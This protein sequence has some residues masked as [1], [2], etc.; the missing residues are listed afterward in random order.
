MYS[1]KSKLVQINTIVDKK[2]L[3]PKSYPYTSSTTKIL[4]DNFKELYQECSHLIN[5]STK[6]LIV[7]IGS[8]DGNL[9][10]NFQK[11]H[12]VLGITPEKIGNL[13]NKKGI[14]T[15]IRYFDNETSNYILKKFG[16]AKIITA[17][18]VF[19]H[20]ENI[21][22]VVKNVLKIL[23]DDGVFITESHYLVTLIK[24]LQY[25]TIYHEHLRY[26]SL[27]SLKY[28]FDRHNLSIFHAK[29]ISTHGGSIR[30]YVARKGKFKTQQSV[31]KIISQEKNFLNWKNFKKF[32]HNVILSKKKLLKFLNTIVKK[33]NIIYGIGA[34]SRAS[35]LV[36]YLNLTKNTIKYIC[37][38]DG[39]HKIGSYMPGT[40]IP[41]VSEKKLY[42]DQPKYVLL[43][44]WHIHKELVSN[45]KKRG[46]KGKYIVPLPKPKIIG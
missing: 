13:A 45:L 24:Q 9:L 38:I 12:K 29:K 21:N 43:L 35:T 23:D 33:G 10:S 26:Y 36:N 1:E 41:I 4:R 34:P 18:N 22:D 40:K 17:T 28:L 11:K 31:K 15:L 25:D 2:I 46:F 16:R 6:D 27:L 30:V 20:I 39:S 42:I 19:A 32:R 37:E 3:F 5:P 44:S 14:K 8:N 7:D